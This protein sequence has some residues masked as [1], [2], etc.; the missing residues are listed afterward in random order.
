MIGNVDEI[1]TEENLKKAYNID[2]RITE[3]KGSDGNI[4]KTCVPL[5]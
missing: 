3:V 1:V 2:V 4:I 5:I